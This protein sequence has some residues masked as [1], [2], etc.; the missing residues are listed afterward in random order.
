M[1]RWRN[2]HLGSL[3]SLEYGSA[4][5]A[6]SRTGQGF[7]VYGSN[8]V[9]GSHDTA[10]VAGPG[11]IVGRKGSV[12]AIKWSQA[13]FWPIDTAYWVR[14]RVNLDLRWMYEVLSRLGLDALDSSTGVPGL[15]RYDAYECPVL[16]P[17]LDEQRRIAEILDTTDE[18]IN[19]TERVIAKLDITSIALNQAS[20]SREVTDKLVR[21][22]D[23]CR[24]LGGKRLPAGHSYSAQRTKYRYLRVADFF[25]REVDYERLMPLNESTFKALSRYE[26]RSGELFISIAGSIGFAGV[27]NPPTGMRTI[28][29]EN[30]ARIMPSDSFI[31][32]FLALQLNSRVVADQVGAEIGTGGGVPKLALHRLANIRINCPTLSTQIKITQLHEAGRVA[33]DSETRRL[34]KLRKFRDGL[35]SDL[36]SGRVKT[37]A[38]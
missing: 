8:G 26:I 29:T 38:T 12:G 19:A 9:V 36:L 15:N 11:I 33:R 34:D 25:R 28:L 5:H 23:E 16:T 21:L 4:L 13:D 20:F 31:P 17:P 24:V 22:G 35:A 18:S 1:S 7:P 27:N 3:V 10:L 30:A 14:P 37:V 32:A 6:D 2:E